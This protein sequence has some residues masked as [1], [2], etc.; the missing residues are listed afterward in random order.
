MA[1]QR[2][3]DKDS[4]S[5]YTCLQK[6]VDMAAQ[7]LDTGAGQIVQR[8]LQR[9]HMKSCRCQ[10]M[11][12]FLPVGN[13]PQHTMKQDD[14]RTLAGISL[15][16]I[17]KLLFY[18]KGTAGKRH[19]CNVVGQAYTLEWNYPLPGSYG[20]RVCKEP[21][22]DITEALQLL[23]PEERMRY[24][25]FRSSR[26]K[27]AFLLGRL[28]LRHVLGRIYRKAPEEVEVRV[29][30]LGRPCVS[31]GYVSLSHSGNQAWAVWAPFPV[32]IDIEEIRNCAPE[33]SRY[34]LRVEEL[35]YLQASDGSM[36][37]TLIWLW[38]LKEAVLKARGSG[39][40]YSPRK[41]H[42]HLSGKEGGVSLATDEEGACWRLAW[43]REDTVYW[44]I[45]CSYECAE[46]MPL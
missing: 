31:R 25:G 2:V 36:E 35:G 24:A 45:A 26:R 18:L 33:L 9:V 3:P 10:P 32:G 8:E 44:A 15:F 19:I 20:C 1:T 43:G 42:L 37:E 27:E 40:R 46:N 34:F 30:A 22:A 29:D 5:L 23:S 14:G 6:A 7:G 28:A 38:T 21:E 4:R 16:Q 17:M 41:I 12:D 39:L 11:H 13:I